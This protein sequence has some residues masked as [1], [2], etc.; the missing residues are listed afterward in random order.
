[1]LKRVYLLFLLLTP[2]LFVKAQEAVAP[3]L[4][5]K[6]ALLDAIARELRRS[7]ISFGSDFT[8]W[9]LHR[10]KHWQ[11][12]EASQTEKAFVDAVN[13]ALEEFD[14]SH[15]R[16]ASDRRHALS[17]SGK[18]IGLGILG[19]E[20]EEGYRVLLAIPE[21]PG[22]LAGLRP[23][24]LILSVNGKTEVTTDNLRGKTGLEKMLVWQRGQEELLATVTTATFSWVLPNELTWVRPDIALISVHSFSEVA[25]DRR[26]IESLFIQAS[27]AKGIIVDL[28]GN[29]GGEISHVQHLLGQLLPRKTG[30]MNLITRKKLDKYR[31]KNPNTAISAQALPKKLGTMLKPMRGKTKRKP[32]KGKVVVLADSLNGSGGELFPAIIQEKGRGVVIG[33]TT[34]G[35]VLGSSTVKLDG[36]RL[37]RPF[38]EVLTFKN[39]RLEKVGV[40]PDIEVS[41]D[42]VIDLDHLVSLALEHWTK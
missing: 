9:D 4:E 38:L 24:D 37:T 40:V 32:Y 26:Q 34:R 35:A 23:G 19:K 21:S 17:E 22:F 11:V 10:E 5:A 27:K 3:D 42:K 15:L 7:A 29:L 20:T 25:Y 14:I 8:Q 2:T 18:A 28:R 31:R 33:N 39:T 16:L 13:D 36:F 30:V 41:H 12:I 1:M 6:T